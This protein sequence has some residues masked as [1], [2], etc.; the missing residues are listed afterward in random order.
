MRQQDKALPT[1]SV[2]GWRSIP[3]EHGRGHRAGLSVAGLVALGAIVTSA[4]GVWADSH[5]PPQTHAEAAI[6]SPSELP[7]GFFVYSWD[8][9]MYKCPFHSFTPVP[10]SNTT[11][12]S[13][14]RISISSCGKWALYARTSSGGPQTFII[15]L[16]GAH[17]KRK[18]GRNHVTIGFWRSSPLGS[19]MFG[20]SS[21]QL[22]ATPFTLSDSGVVFGSDRV[23]ADLSNSGG[24]FA[25][26]AGGSY[27]LANDMLFGRIIEIWQGTPVVRSGF[28]TIP[29]GGLGRATQDN[30]Y[31]WAEAP[32][33]STYGCQH[34]ISWDGSHVVS[35]PGHVGDS[36]CV[37]WDHKG[38][39]VGPSLKDGDSAI[40]LDSYAMER[41]YGLNWCPERYRPGGYEL[42]D[43]KR[44]SFT[45]DSNYVVGVQTS[46]A[47]DG[48]NGVWLIKWPTNTWYRLTP[49]ED[50]LPVEAVDAYF[51]EY[52][53]EVVQDTSR[54]DTVPAPVDS[55][56]PR[57]RIIRPN[58]GE[59]FHVGEQC[60][61]VVSSEKPGEGQIFLHLEGGEHVFALPGLN[62][63][64]DP[65]RDSM[66]TFVIP[67]SF[68]AYRYNP[69]SGQTEPFPVSPVSSACFV[70]I[71][72]YNDNT[73]GDFSDGP[74]AIQ[75]ST[76]ADCFSRETSRAVVRVRRTARGIRLEGLWDASDATRFANGIVD[77]S[78]FMLNGR[79]A[80]RWKGRTNAHGEV[81][82]ER[83][84]SGSLD[85]PAGGCWIWQAAIGP[86]SVTTLPAVF[87]P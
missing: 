4:N 23:L 51:G 69:A 8:G 40:T 63:S 58:G 73:Y 48:W 64:I 67:E 86:R 38:L 81:L 78:A 42:G 56:D 62:A 87:S 5:C 32:H 71:R 75:P 34:S 14:A 26:Q 45:N 9:R 61:V 82:L 76:A 31:R 16:D 28:L 60:T 3:K 55:L 33:L 11:Y 77:I 10:V 39:V 52:R 15:R 66:V 2:G 35:S 47:N 46:S 1:S 17:K 29:D 37:P 20:M 44:W 70:E 50:S 41:S 19:A 13:P 72:D 85:V 7:H 27:G 65:T 6:G 24:A 79:L 83:G 59:V 80:C 25:F 68:T 53:A 22:V 49:L 30:I 54:P 43:F 57:Y 74:F 12:D 18:P 21:S 84:A 36:L